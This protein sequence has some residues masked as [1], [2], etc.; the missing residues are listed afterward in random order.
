M[1]H[2]LLDRDARS[3][4]LEDSSVHCCITSPPYF[5]LRHYSDSPAEIGRPGRDGLKGYLGALAEV[6]GEVRRV[7]RRD[8][9]LILNLGDTYVN[10]QLLGIPW[11]VA[12]R[13]QSEGWILRSDSI[14][15]KPNGMPDSAA[16]RP[17]ASH[18][19]MFL[20][21]KTRRNYWDKFAVARPERSSVRMCAVGRS[22]CK[23][24]A[25]FPPALILPYI[26]QATSEVGVCV[27]CGAG[28]K[29]VVEKI[30]APT[31]PGRTN[32]V[33][34]SGK[35][36][37]DRRRHVTTVLTKG[38]EPS[39]RCPADAAGNFPIRRPL[40]LDPFAGT[41]TTAVACEWSGRDSVMVDLNPDYLAMGARRIAAE[42]P[43]KA[44]KPPRDP[45]APLPGQLTFP[46]FGSAT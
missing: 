25:S 16:D 37:Q 18:E 4:P 33:D 24:F 7:L 13:L 23:H 45:R 15:G 34:E 35:A 31:R 10:K 43:P 44:K 26:K 29:R 22:K 5:N 36:K 21:T 28:W 40:V 2:Q 8:G 39:C 11:L 14:W 30:R 38:W 41:C 46:E 9:T 27:A 19:Y 3:L 42:R 6:F 1:A 20:F 12:F 32:A 17:A